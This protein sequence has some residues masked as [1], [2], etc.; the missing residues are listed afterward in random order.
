MQ[1][2]D[3][4]SIH[5][6]GIPGAVLMYNA[7]KSVTDFIFQKYPNVRKVG[8]L[9]G[10]GNNGGDG[11]VIAHLLSHKGVEV[12]VIA[13]AQPDI[14]V[15][16]AQIYLNL[17][18]KERINVT[19]PKDKDEMVELTK[20]LCDRDII[21][22]SLLGTGTKGQVRE[23]TASVIK[24]IPQG[25]TIVSVDLPSG[26][27]GDTGEIC[28]VCVKANHTITFAAAKKGIVGKE[29]TGELIVTDIGIPEICLD[30]DKWNEFIKQ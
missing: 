25:P 20:Q 13:L 24:A 9:A 4:R 7:G 14:Y 11:F 6:L 23:P 10:K 26:M 5:E 2:A 3:R 16:D 15:G 22:D 18:L 28:G 27:N 19:F 8:V 29:E 12:K 1:E 21:I 17:C 30:D